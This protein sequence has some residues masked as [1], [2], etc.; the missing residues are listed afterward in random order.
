MSVDLERSEVQAQFKSDVQEASQAFEQEM[1]P[2]A[3]DQE[4]DMQKEEPPTPELQLEFEMKDWKFV[5]DLPEFFMSTSEIKY[6]VP[7]ITMRR[8][9]VS[10]DVPVVVMKT[11]EGP[12]MP[13]TTCGWRTV[14]GPFGTKYDT[15]TCTVEYV[16]SYYDTPT[17]EMRTQEYSLDVPT[18]D[19]TEEQKIAFDLPAVKMTP[20]EITVSYPAIKAFSFMPE[21]PPDEI[22]EFN[23]RQA[24]RADKWNSV[25]VERS[26]SFKKNV[27][28]AAV[29]MM[30]R[31]EDVE[32]KNLE[33]INANKK[34]ELQQ[35]LDSAKVHRDTLADQKVESSDQRRVD[36]ENSILRLSMEVGQQDSI[37]LAQVSA[38][39]TAMHNAIFQA[40]EKSG[41]KPE[42]VND[43]LP[44][45]G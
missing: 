17:V 38:L 19:G 45:V 34:A 3:A 33:S 6:T 15:W 16:P 25:R 2:I 35:Q 14:D 11:V 37:S 23:G 5:V 26:A 32:V 9:G 7:K 20:R 24:A 10:L 39:R 12:R 36:A 27:G 41:L 8:Q 31:L 44:N 22:N 42:D 40:V 18:V 30:L 4:A 43:M 21:V 28:R 29:R 13:Q 1:K